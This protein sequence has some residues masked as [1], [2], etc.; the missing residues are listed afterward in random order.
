MIATNSPAIDAL[1]A[2]LDGEYAAIYAY[3]LIG[4]QLSGSAQLRARRALNSHRALRDQLR[5]QITA[6]GEQPPNPAAAYQT[7]QAVTS[8][9]TATALAV[10]IEQRLVRSWSALAAATSGDDRKSAARTASES[11]V[12]AISWGSVSQAFPG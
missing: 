6:T 7:P 4:S 2:T 8:S 9:A 3:G 1:K 12:R 5:A 11:A 10:V